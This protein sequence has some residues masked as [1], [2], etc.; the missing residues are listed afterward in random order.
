[1]ADSDHFGERSRRAACT[2]RRLLEEPRGWSPFA[3]HVCPSRPLPGR[4]GRG[5]FDQRFCYPAFPPIT[6]RTAAISSFTPHGLLRCG[7]VCN[8]SRILGT[9]DPPVRNTNFLAI[10]G[11]SL[12]TASC[13]SRPVSSGIITSLTTAAKDSVSRRFKA[14]V[15][16]VTPTQSKSCRRA[17]R[18]D[19]KTMSSS[20]TTSI[21]GLFTDLDTPVT[22]EFTD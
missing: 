16:L 9:S 5:R 11:R 3:G 8:H 20:S 17:R 10:S 4:T 12:T 19:F 15:G 13:R 21:R 14:S 1:M 22:Q 7:V 2:T 18:V 6:S